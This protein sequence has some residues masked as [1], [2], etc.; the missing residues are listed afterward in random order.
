[1]LEKL[2]LTKKL[3]KAEYK[4]KIAVLESQLGTEV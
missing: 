4:E 1:M 2:D 3:E